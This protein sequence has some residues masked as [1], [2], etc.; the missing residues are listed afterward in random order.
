MN[1]TGLVHLLLDGH[2]DFQKKHENYATAQEALNIAVNERTTAKDY[3]N[4]VIRDLE[5]E[6]K[7]IRKQQ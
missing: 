3:R 4:A 6:L 5:A 7:Q 2:A 1:L